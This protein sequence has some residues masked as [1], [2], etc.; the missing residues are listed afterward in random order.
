MLTEMQKAF[1]KMAAKEPV[2]VRNDRIDDAIKLL[3]SQSPSLFF[4]DSDRKPDPAMRNRVFYNQPYSL[5]PDQYK[6][7]VLPLGKRR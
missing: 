2:E 7:H 4:D 3:K 6:S 5:M 1:L